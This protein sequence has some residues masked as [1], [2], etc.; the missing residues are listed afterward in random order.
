LL[1]SEEPV[2]NVPAQRRL[3]RLGRNQQ[4]A[5]EPVGDTDALSVLKAAGRF[6]S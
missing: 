2:E 6:K 4:E 5:N 3:G 1:Q